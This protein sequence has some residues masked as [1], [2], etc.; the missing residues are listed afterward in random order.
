MDNISL[1]I[2]QARDIER[3]LDGFTHAVQLDPENGEAWNNIACLYAFLASISCLELGHCLVFLFIKNNVPA[4]PYKPT[5]IQKHL[6]L[7]R[8]DLNCLNFEDLNHML[9]PLCIIIIIFLKKSV[10]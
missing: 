8:A 7:F 1:K 5:Y 6:F 10:C 2:I 3:A 4:N 9:Q